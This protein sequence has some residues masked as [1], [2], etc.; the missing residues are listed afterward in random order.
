MADHGGSS[1][2]PKTRSEDH[3]APRGGME[4]LSALADHLATAHRADQVL[5]RAEQALT[6]VLGPGAAKVESASTSHGG[7]QVTVAVPGSP[8]ARIAARPTLSPASLAF[9]ETTARVAGLALQRLEAQEARS[10]AE[11]E[12]AALSGQILE[13]AGRERGRIA[14][15]IHDELLPH[16]AAA[17]IQ[18]DN[19][20]TAV[21]A[22]EVERVGEL[23]NRTHHAVHDGIASLREVLDDLQHESVVPGRLR[24]ALEESVGELRL[25]EEVDAR[26]DA[27]DVL[28]PLPFAVELLILETVRGCLANVGRHARASSVVVSL[29]VRDCHIAV[30]VRDD[31]CGFDPQQT[32]RGHGLA[33]MAQRVEMAKGRFAVRSTPGEGATVT[34]EV[35]R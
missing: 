26:L 4:Q 30:E 5:A 12:C 9:V 29:S 13:E 34:M 16:L 17:T 21:S 14:T 31:G 25:K 11:D 22:G 33:L 6:A 35:P 18:A 20:R 7:D 2:S 27:P 28:P 1:G 15:R 23:A 10:R 3:D 19:V 32:P 24:E 8:T